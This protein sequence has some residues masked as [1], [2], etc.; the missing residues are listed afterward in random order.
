MCE[1]NNVETKTGTNGSV[2]PV[3]SEETVVRVDEFGRRCL[4]LFA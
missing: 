1:R 2:L 3:Q 4:H